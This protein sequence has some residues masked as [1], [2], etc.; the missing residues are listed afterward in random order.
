MANEE[1]EE[2]REDWSI[3]SY[4]QEADLKDYSHSAAKN[5]E[6]IRSFTDYRRQQ[7]ESG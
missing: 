3:F 2:A 4:L 7:P 5:L 1:C 6:D